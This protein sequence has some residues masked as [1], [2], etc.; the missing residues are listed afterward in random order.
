MRYYD[1]QK[2]FYIISF[3]PEHKASP[4]SSNQKIR[5]REKKVFDK[6]KYVV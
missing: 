6:T 5:E 4:Y 1:Q 3:K 2:D